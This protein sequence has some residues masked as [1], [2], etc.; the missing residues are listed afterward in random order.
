VL[1]G[2]QDAAQA[3]ELPQDFCPLSGPFCR[4]TCCT[5]HS[6]TLPD[7]GLHRPTGGVRPS[8]V[9]SCCCSRTCALS[10][11]SSDSH[12]FDPWSQSLMSE[13]NRGER[14]LVT[15]SPLGSILVLH[16]A[17]FHIVH[18]LSRHRPRQVPPPSLPRHSPRQVPQTLM[19]PLSWSSSFGTSLPKPL[20]PKP[21]GTLNPDK[22]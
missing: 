9:A 16:F 12:R 10:F 21:Y 11:S 1:D 19:V 2:A 3:L 22:S 13:L 14:N 7:A 18:S 6:T 15:V 20:N 5:Q 4:T 17:E 8:S